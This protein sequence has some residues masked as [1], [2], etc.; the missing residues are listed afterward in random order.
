MFTEE[1]EQDDQEFAPDTLLPKDLAEHLE[2]RKQQR[3]D[4][5]ITTSKLTGYLVT[6]SMNATGYFLAKSLIYFGGSINF[7]IAI[8]LCF[9]CCAI[10]PLTGLNDFRVNYKDG[11]EID[12]AQSTVKVAFGLGSAALTTYLAVKDFDHYQ[13]MTNQTIEA[14]TNDVRNF[15]NQS[16]S[17]DPFSGMVTLGLIASAALLLLLMVFKGQKT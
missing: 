13:K 3:R 7:P 17:V 9:T 2:Q 15:E 8:A 16:P 1:L 14:I 6:W 12:N 5:I 11:I 10:V 4:V